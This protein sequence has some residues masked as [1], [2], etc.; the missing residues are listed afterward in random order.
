MAALKLL[1]NDSETSWELSSISRVFESLILYSFFQNWKLIRER[2]ETGTANW[3][4]IH[5]HQQWKRY[6]RILSGLFRLE[7]KL[8]VECVSKL[9]W[10]C[11]ESA[12]KTRRWH[13]DQFSDPVSIVLTRKS[14]KRK[15]WDEM[16]RNYPGTASRIRPVRN[17]SETAQETSNRALEIV[18][19]SPS[20]SFRDCINLKWEKETALKRPVEHAP[21]PLH[22][23]TPS[24][25]PS[26]THTHTH[27]HT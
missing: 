24:H 15:R 26:H 22:T 1:W 7:W 27:T 25:S 20:G 2:E 14:R 16:I 18:Y 21:L 11:S 17:C 6:W 8:P 5:T 10:D 23:D 13:R 3:T 4:H 19:G 12:S 9:L